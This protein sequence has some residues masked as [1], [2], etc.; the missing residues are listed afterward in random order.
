MKKQICQAQPL[1][2]VNDVKLSSRWYQKMLGCKSGHGGNEYEQLVIGDRIILQ[3][4]AWEFEHGHHTHMGKPSM[5]SRG[6][7]VLL[8]F[9]VD[10]F[11]KA[12]KVIK[13]AKVKILENVKVN[14]NAQHREIWIQDPDGYVVVLAS[15]YNDI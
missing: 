11:D 5:K 7:G 4:H 10:D 1:I 15:H 6:N 3:L 2:A 14:P 9:L 12:L 8:W 13:K